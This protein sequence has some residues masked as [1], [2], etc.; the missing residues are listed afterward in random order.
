MELSFLINAVK[1]Y[2]LFS[3]MQYL[4]I[5]ALSVILII[6]RFLNYLLENM[7]NLLLK[8]QFL[9]HFSFELQCLY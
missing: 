4:K 6:N 9:F 3:N 1:I 5:C 2:K 7:M 8:I